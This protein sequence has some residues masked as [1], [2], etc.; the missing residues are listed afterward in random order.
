M[1]SIS[2]LLDCIKT[3]F[4]GVLE[5]LGCGIWITQDWKSYHY[6]LILFGGDRFINNHQGNTFQ[7]YNEIPPQAY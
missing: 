5:T 6:S 4:K 1:I 7:N 2:R 3:I